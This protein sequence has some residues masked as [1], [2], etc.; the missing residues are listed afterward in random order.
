MI[1]DYIYCKFISFFWL[2]IIDVENWCDIYVVYWRVVIRWELLFDVDCNGWIECLFLL[3]WLMKKY[4]LFEL[5]NKKLVF[6]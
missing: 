1:V 6:V 2:F 5:K 3:V 4:Y